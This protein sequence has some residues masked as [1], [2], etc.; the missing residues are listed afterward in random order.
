MIPCMNRRPNVRR[1]RNALGAFAALFVL[2]ASF[3]SV[4]PPRLASRDRRAPELTWSNEAH[5]PVGD[6]ERDRERPSN[7]AVRL[8]RGADPGP[9]R[10]P[11]VLAA[12]LQARPAL[13]ADAGRPHGTD[14]SSFPALGRSRAPRCPRGPPMV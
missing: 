8:R 10:P 3:G 5:T 11:T 13:P 12:I 9:W 1:K 4:A 2:L 7:P 6:V 14:A